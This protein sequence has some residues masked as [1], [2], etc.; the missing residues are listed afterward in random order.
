MV[1]LKLKKKEKK[2][3]KKTKQTNKQ[4]KRKR[5]SPFCEIW[6]YVKIGQSSFFMAEIWAEKNKFRAFQILT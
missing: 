6:Q 1:P 3:K 2:K 5:F 4:K